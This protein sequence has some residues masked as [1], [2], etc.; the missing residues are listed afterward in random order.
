M[1]VRVHDVLLPARKQQFS[2]RSGQQIQTP[3]PRPTGGPLIAPDSDGLVSRHFHM[4]S[5]DG[6][7]KQWPVLIGP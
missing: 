6:K 5:I 3:T 2:C 7:T 4:Q 1:N